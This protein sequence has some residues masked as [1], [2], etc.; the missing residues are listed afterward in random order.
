MSGSMAGLDGLR[1]QGRMTWIDQEHG[2]LATPG[3]ILMALAHDG[4]E[5]CKREMTTSRRDRRPAGGLWQGVNPRT[6][7]EASAIWV[8]RSAGHQAILFID[9]NGESLAEEIEAVAS[10][11]HDSASLVEGEGRGEGPGQRLDGRL[12]C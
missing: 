6:G 12:E 9:I 5:E 2:W 4:F 3:E 7:S 11:C 1:E 10:A 8:N